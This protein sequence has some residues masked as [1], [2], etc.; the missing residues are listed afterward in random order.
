VLS[1]VSMNDCDILIEDSEGIVIHQ[2]RLGARDTE[3][4]SLPRADLIGTHIGGTAWHI[5]TGSEFT[6]AIGTNLSEED[7][8]IDL[9]VDKVTFNQ[10]VQIDLA[11]RHDLTPVIANKSGVLR[12]FVNSMSSHQ[13]QKVEVKLGGTYQGN[14]LEPIIKEVALKH[15]PFAEA[16]STKGVVHFELNDP[17]WLREGTSFYVELDPN[18]KLAEFNEKNNRYPDEDSLRSFHFK[19]RSAMRIKLFPIISNNGEYSGDISPELVR[20]AEG[21]LKSIYPLSEVEVLVGEALNSEAY[22]NDNMDSWDLVLSELA[23][24]KTMQVENDPLEHDV[25][26]YGVIDCEGYCGA[27]LGLAT[28]NERAS[29]SLLVGMGRVD[30]ISHRE[31]AEVLAHELGHNHGRK[32][33][34]AIDSE[35]CWSSLNHDSDYPFNSEQV[36]YGQIGKTGYHHFDHRLINK[37]SFHDMMSYCKQKWISNYTY[38]ALYDFKDELDRFFQLVY[39]NDHDQ[40]GREKTEGVMVYGKLVHKDDGTIE[41]ELHF[42]HNLKHRPSA[43]AISESEQTAVVNFANSKKLEVSVP[44]QVPKSSLPVGYHQIELFD[45]KS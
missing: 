1:N 8:R 30:T 4:F 44:V 27:G 14:A 33:V 15:T 20:E 2:A 9:S 7:L 34:N 42:Q 23:A 32:H 12:V 5:S 16:D 3:A 31:F 13:S 17:N 35:D 40:H 36:V 10:A 6:E 26:Y 45:L 41:S 43:F 28:I 37:E 38:S 19:E 25:F 21:Y 18:N 24:H 22:I 39:K 11:D 29:S